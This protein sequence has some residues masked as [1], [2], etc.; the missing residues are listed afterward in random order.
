MAKWIGLIAGGGDLP[1]KTL[2]AMRAE[3]YQVACVGLRGCCDP[4]LKQMCQKFCYAGALHIGKWFRK[5]R[6]WNCGQA[7]LIGKVHKVNIYDPLQ[8]AQMWPDLVAAKI[9]FGA[10]RHNR[11]DG[12]ILTTL[13]N[14]MQDRGI[15]LMDQT[16]F[17]P[18]SVA[19]E[20]V[21][22]KLKPT[23]V[24]EGNIAYGWDR[25]SEISRMDIG[26][27]IAVYNSTVIA[28]EA[29]EGTDRMIQRAGELCRKGG[30]TMLKGSHEHHDMRIDVPTV[31]DQTIQKLHEHGAT[32]LVLKA[33][34]TIMV[35][36][37]KTIEL[38]DKLG[39][40]IVGKV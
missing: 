15:E 13:A 6:R 29:V 19:D 34:K 27:S 31:G 11:G 12:A 35:D 25:V 3:G 17:L 14:T 38:A 30:W 16:I 23:A 7:V 37:Q 32:C 1:E 5:L 9:W 26:Q 8:L 40:T 21:M 2:L 28:V 33:G 20:G 18:D 22:T 36:K 10:L 24:Q 4:K 39:I